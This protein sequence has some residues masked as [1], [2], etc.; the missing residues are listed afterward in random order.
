LPLGT[1]VG[2]SSAREPSLSLVG[3][4]PVMQGEGT[5]LGSMY[6]TLLVNR[7]W[8]SGINAYRH[9]GVSVVAQGQRLLRPTVLITG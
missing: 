1:L 7:K 6:Q 3:Q 9:F 4:C 5:S 8:W 2:C